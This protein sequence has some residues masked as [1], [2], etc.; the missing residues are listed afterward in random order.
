M[1]HRHNHIPDWRKTK[2]DSLN[3]VYISMCKNCK[4]K[5]S[6]TQFRKARWGKVK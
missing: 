5:L 3:E 1:K 4:K 6:S 2:F